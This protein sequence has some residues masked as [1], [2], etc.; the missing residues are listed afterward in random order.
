[1]SRGS[2]KIDNDDTRSVSLYDEEALYTAEIFASVPWIKEND[3]I[4]VDGF[5]FPKEA[6]PALNALIGKLLFDIQMNSY[7]DRGAQARLLRHI[8]AIDFQALRGGLIAFSPLNHDYYSTLGSES[9]VATLRNVFPGL[10]REFVQLLD[11]EGHSALKEAVGAIPVNEVREQVRNDAISVTDSS[12]K[13]AFKVYKL[14]TDEGRAILEKFSPGVSV[15]IEAI[16]EM[17]CET[18]KMRAD[19][20]YPSTAADLKDVWDRGLRVGETIPEGHVE[21]QYD[22]STLNPKDLIEMMQR[23]LQNITLGLLYKLPD[24]L[25]E[26][27]MAKVTAALDA[28][29]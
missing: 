5:D 23:S 2:L 15:A 22:Y 8:H 19:L 20:S 17:I 25:R 1:M 10:L 9:V 14:L 11:G 13:N 4:L 28:T 3:A 18:I 29:G 16:L 24:E 12:H 7:V 26:S 21:P 27:V 6:I